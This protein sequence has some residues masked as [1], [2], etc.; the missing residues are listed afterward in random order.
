MT[1]SKRVQELE[2]ERNQVSGQE[3]SLKSDLSMNS[4]SK[5][6]PEK[7]GFP[8]S[9]SKEK[10]QLTAKSIHE[11]KKINHETTE[12][13]N[14]TLEEWDSQS[15]S[16]VE[17][18]IE[19]M[20]TDLRAKNLKFHCKACGSNF[21]SA[22]GVRHHMSYFQKEKKR[23]SC[24]KC[25]K[26]F[27]LKDQLKK[28]ESVHEKEYYPCSQCDKILKS[29]DGLTT[30]IKSVHEGQKKPFSCD[31]CSKCFALKG[32]LKRH[33]EC[34]HKDESYPCSQCG[35]V[36]YYNGNLKTHIET[37]HE[38]QNKGQNNF[39]C[40]YCSRGFGRNQGLQRHLKSQ[41]KQESPKPIKSD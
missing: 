3:P 39:I 9:N 28:H 17:N 16:I 26:C 5:S 8:A 15:E 25:S 13:V 20:D 30:H 35:K 36:L 33:R 4:E 12:V 19:A 27:A 21:S 7:K 32:Q 14:E 6:E 37:V 2:K 1:L 24:D 11:E 38:G 31:K 22:F 23:F 18:Q 29:K 10:K 34:V 40:E 41:H